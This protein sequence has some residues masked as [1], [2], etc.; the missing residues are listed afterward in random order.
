[1]RQTTSTADENAKALEIAEQIAALL[2][3]LDSLQP[4]SVHAGPGRISGPGV[5]IRRDPN[6]T[7]AARTGR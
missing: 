3:E 6:G 4:G 1:M 7:W 5:E 2:G